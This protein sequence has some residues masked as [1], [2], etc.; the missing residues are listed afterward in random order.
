MQASKIANHWV[1]YFIMPVIYLIKNLAF[2]LRL[3]CCIINNI[4]CDKPKTN[5]TKEDKRSV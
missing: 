1:S 5:K 3:L 4:Y 2:R